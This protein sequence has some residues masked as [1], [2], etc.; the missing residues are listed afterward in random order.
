LKIAETCAIPE[1]RMQK[2]AGNLAYTLV[3]SSKNI[4]TEAKS[5]TLNGNLPPVFTCLLDILVELSQI[6]ISKNS[7]TMGG[8]RMAS[9]LF[10]I[11]THTSDGKKTA[12]DGD[13][14]MDGKVQ[15]TEAVQVL[16]D[17]FLKA[18]NVQLQSE[19]LDRLLHIFSSN[20]ENYGLCQR[21]RT[22]PLLIQN[23][24]AFPQTLQE[25]LLK[26]LEC[27]VIVVNH[28][29]EQELLSLCCLFQQH[30][31]VS[32]C[33]SILLFFT[34]VLSFDK[35]YKKILREAGALEALIDDLKKLDTSSMLNFQNLKSR[36]KMS[37][38]K[39]LARERCLRSSSFPSSADISSYK[40][41]LFGEE[42]TV[43]I[44]WD[45]LITMLKGA[46]GNQMA[47]RRENGV[48]L[49][50][51]LLSQSCHRGSVL[52]LLTC[53]ICEDINQVSLICM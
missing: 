25:R 38:N 49:V 51:P 4:S 45:C 42:S 35:E 37:I 40:A 11:G 22:L 29:P 13:R 9:E 15:D 27:A 32:L 17:I 18:K 39:D 41:Q 12:G 5:N 14:H 23:M 8:R 26:I 48:A 28:V 50:L 53:L 7:I 10:V 24:P 3:N 34:K 36:A 46:E 33:K 16:Q 52:R 43:S 47:F 31:P 20:V 44:A 19:V 6:G 21:L 1:D 2:D 30:L